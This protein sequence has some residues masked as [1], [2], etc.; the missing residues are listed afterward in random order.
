LFFFE[1]PIIVYEECVNIWKSSHSY[2]VPC[3]VLPIAFQGDSDD[4]RFDCCPVTYHKTNGGTTVLQ[5]FDF[6][7]FEST[8]VTVDIRSF[9]SKG[10]FVLTF[11]NGESDDL[12]KVVTHQFGKS[13]QFVV[14][15]SKYYSN[16]YVKISHTPFIGAF[17]VSSD[18]IFIASNEKGTK[19]SDDIRLIREFRMSKSYWKGLDRDRIEVMYYDSLQ[20]NGVNLCRPIEAHR[21]YEENLIHCKSLYYRYMLGVMDC[22]SQCPICLSDIKCGLDPKLRCGHGMCFM[23]FLQMWKNGGNFVKCPFCRRIEYYYR[24]EK[25]VFGNVGFNVY[26]GGDNCLDNCVICDGRLLRIF[27][28]CKA[29]RNDNIFMMMK[30]DFEQYVDSKLPKNVYVCRDCRVTYNDDDIC[31]YCSS[32]LVR[33]H[34]KCEKFGV[35]GINKLF[36]YYCSQNVRV[37]L[38]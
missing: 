11:F 21:S 36:C 2:R 27:K 3:K 8:V 13:Q 17:S 33:G 38:K 31:Q 28:P 30:G 26:E 6:V 5:G 15:F 29:Y 19:K 7:N 25:N 32:P 24:S 20:E 1:Q 4:V 37:R 12:I 14:T 9:A 35:N 18:V 23:C 16:M 22:D 10:R 34:G